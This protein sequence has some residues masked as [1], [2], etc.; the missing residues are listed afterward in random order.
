MINALFR[1]PVKL[2]LMIILAGCSGIAQLQEATTPVDL[3]LLTPKSTFSS[4]LPR[5]KQQIVVIEPTAT[6]AVDTDR[7]AV[8]PNALEVQYLPG[9]RWVDRAPLIVQKLLIE[10]YENSNRVSAVGSSTIG[11]RAD[12]LIATDIREFQAIAPPLEV[13]GPLVVEVT[14]NIKVVDA[15]EDR[16]IGSRSFI[17]KAPAATDEPSDV[18]SAFDEALGDAMRDAVEW[19]VRLMVKH[20]AVQSSD[21]EALGTSAARPATDGAAVRS[22]ALTDSQ[23]SSAAQGLRPQPTETATR[24]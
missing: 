2:A 17:E 13:G 10:S 8:Q 22:T 1:V 7:I 16:I 3:Y 24:L 9:S 19:S 4:S 15:Y 6:A 23:N 5:L 20:A 12:Y 11:L 14:L 18:I 21:N